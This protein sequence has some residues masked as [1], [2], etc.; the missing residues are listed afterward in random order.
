[1]QTAASF[2]VHG[3]IG[4]LME[5][6]MAPEEKERRIRGFLLYALRL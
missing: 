1:M 2:C 6:G 5:E 4:I 3:Q